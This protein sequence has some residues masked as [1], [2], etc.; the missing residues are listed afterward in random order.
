VR[1]ACC[2][3]RNLAENRLY[4]DGARTLAPVLQQL[5]RLSSLHLNDNSFGYTGI[6]ALDDALSALTMLKELHLQNNRF[7]PHTT[8]V[9][10]PLIAV[11]CR[12]EL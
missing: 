11:G 10:G 3:C 5:T 7:D 1:C 9:L 6:L 2:A 8:D 4:S 12:I